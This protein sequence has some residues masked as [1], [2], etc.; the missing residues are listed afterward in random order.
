MEWVKLPDILP[1]RVEVR[2]LLGVPSMLTAWD[3]V[4]SSSLPEG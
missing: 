4:K 3:R 2:K 1:R